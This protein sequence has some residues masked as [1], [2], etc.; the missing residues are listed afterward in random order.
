MVWT[1]YWARTRADARPTKRRSVTG[2]GHTFSGTSSRVRTVVASGFFM[3]LPSLAK[4]LLKETPTLMVSPV[5]SFTVPRIWS[6]M[7]L[8]SPPKRCMEPVMSSQL[9]SMPKGSTRSVYRS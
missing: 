7:A 6:A 8:P 5:S 9:S 1:P 2:R 3:S 4:T